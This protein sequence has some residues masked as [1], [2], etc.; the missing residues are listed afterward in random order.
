MTYIND[1]EDMSGTIFRVYAFE[2]PSHR[3][4][5]KFQSIIDWF[6]FKNCDFKY[7]PSITAV[8]SSTD[9]NLTY[10]GGS[11]DFI[12]YFADHLK[13]RQAMKLLL[14]LKGFLII[15]S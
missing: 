6:I 7:P 4:L 11:V 14:S 3:F 12:N 2:V 13:F 10:Q 9:G 1:Q 5:V 15:F 8:K